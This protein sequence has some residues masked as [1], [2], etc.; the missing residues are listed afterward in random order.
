MDESIG[1]MTQI[2]MLDTLES[3]QKKKIMMSIIQQMTAKISGKLWVIQN[4]F[5]DKNI[6]MIGLYSK[7]IQYG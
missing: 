3:T 6:L 5:K 1:E 4:T 2:T 7:L